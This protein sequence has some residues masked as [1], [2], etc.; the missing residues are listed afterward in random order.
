MK[1]CEG[2]KQIYETEG[3][4]TEVQSDAIWVRDGRGRVIR[5]EVDDDAADD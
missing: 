4:P 1:G 3:Q 2:L 5:L